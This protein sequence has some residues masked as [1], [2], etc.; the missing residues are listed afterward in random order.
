MIRR[1]NL[2]VHTR[3]LLF[4]VLLELLQ[5]S[6]IWSGAVCLE[7]L[8]VPV[9]MDDKKAATECQVGLANSLIGERS[10]LLL[11]YL[12]VGKLLLVLLPAGARG[13]GH[14]E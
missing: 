3:L 12:I 8:N 1:T 5:R 6:S 11:F 14:G 7:H 13:A 4:N 2:L 9:Q 10:N